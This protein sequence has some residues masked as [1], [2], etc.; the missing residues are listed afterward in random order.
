MSEAVERQ[1][2]GAERL[3]ALEQVHRAAV[4]GD[5]YPAVARG[6]LAVV[7]AERDALLVLLEELK[8][9]A[10]AAEA[11]RTALKAVDTGG[12]VDAIG[13]PKTEAWR[14][15]RLDLCRAAS[16]APSL[17]RLNEDKPT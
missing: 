13:D 1:L 2:A 8:P 16:A 15:A 5:A 14:N 4:S 17:S 10:E 7:I 11:Y 12:M 9:L 6:A 3:T